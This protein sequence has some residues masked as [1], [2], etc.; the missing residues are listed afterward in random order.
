MRVFGY[1]SILAVSGAVVGGVT[2]LIVFAIAIPSVMN[3]SM[4]IEMA[5]NLARIRPMIPLFTSYKFLW[6]FL[7]V[8]A[9]MASCYTSLNWMNSKARIIVWSKECP[10]RMHVMSVMSS[11]F[12]VIVGLL[13]I[14][15][16]T[17]YGFVASDEAVLFGNAMNIPGLIAG[18]VLCVL[19]WFIS[20]PDGLDGDLRGFWS[21]SRDHR[22]K[23][24]RAAARGMA[25]ALITFLVALA[26]AHLYTFIFLL[27]TKV[28]TYSSE[29]A[30]G[31]YVRLFTAHSLLGAMSFL[32][33]FGAIP[34]LSSEG[35]LPGTRRSFAV[36]YLGMVA[37]FIVGFGGLSSY[38][39]SH[40]DW[41]A[42]GL[43]EVA[44]LN[45][46]GSPEMTLVHMGTDPAANVKLVSWPMSAWYGGVFSDGD[47]PVDDATSE[48]LAKFLS[49]KKATSRFRDDAVSAMAHIYMVRWEPQHLS[50]SF[51][52]VRTIMGPSYGISLIH[53]ASSIA[54]LTTAAPA[55]SPNIKSL[56]GFSDT[57]IY[58]IP[59]RAAIRLAK[60]WWRFGRPE[61]ARELLELAKKGGAP[62]DELKKAAISSGK[63]FVEGRVRGKVR[64][65]GAPNGTRLKVG[66]YLSRGSNST[67]PSLRS[68][69]T[70]LSV[71]Q[72][73]K[74]DGSFDFSNLPTGEY[75]LSILAP[76]S[77]VPQTAKGVVVSGRPGLIR[78][79]REKASQNTGTISLKI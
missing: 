4:P 50:T 38:A 6:L 71:S 5:D 2:G 35:F 19:G 65:D 9:L 64:V 61:R 60:G 33:V 67:P 26:V 3:L 76:S 54:F 53:L 69:V 49:K 46:K 16:N 48:K 22:S 62:E 25:L 78:V 12:L 45:P 63:N 40:Y 13:T 43:T 21:L 52:T 68:L 24:I 59:W 79:S 31:G 55:S 75:Y 10:T 51:E 44:G 7:S 27:I 29:I 20:S 57:K 8:V 14:V 39:W 36:P 11:F 15:Q 77:V 17:G 32:M 42:S 73:T 74:E 56:E 23:Y 70:G 28:W 1:F 47:V 66:L 41:K 34:V 18:A 72:W 58:N 30:L 37:I